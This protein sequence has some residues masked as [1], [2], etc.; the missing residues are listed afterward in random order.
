MKGQWIAVIVMALATAALT[1]CG[2]V[3]NL[4]SGHPEPYGD[5]EKD[6]EFAGT[7]R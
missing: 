6:I 3:C 5:V 7:P 2:T 4:T 1:G